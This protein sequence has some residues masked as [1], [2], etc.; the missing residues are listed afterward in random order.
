[1]KFMTNYGK[2][3]TFFDM[4]NFA[5]SGFYNP[6]EHLAFD[7]VIVC[8]NGTAVFKLCVLKIQKHFR[9]KIY[10]LHEETGFT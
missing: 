5:Y 10:K 6:S 3:W 4:Y 8:L 1:M 7:E 2:L 9:I